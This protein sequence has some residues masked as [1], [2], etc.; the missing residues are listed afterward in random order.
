MSSSLPLAV[1]LSWR[2]PRTSPSLCLGRLRVSRWW[3]RRRREV[4]MRINDGWMV[5]SDD[6][7]GLSP[8]FTRS[9]SA[10]FSSDDDDA[11]DLPSPPPPTFVTIL[12]FPPDLAEP[13]DAVAAIIDVHSNLL[14]S[15]SVQTCRLMD[16]RCNIVRLMVAECANS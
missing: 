16:I 7:D 15:T 12:C 9:S 8:C 4:L 3:Q 6:H 1:D 14:Q 2:S 13:R 5:V 11:A 10:L